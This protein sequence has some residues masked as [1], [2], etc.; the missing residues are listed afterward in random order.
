M[1]SFMKASADREYIAS[2]RWKCNKSP[3][4]SHFWIIHGYKM[5]CKYCENV[6]PVNTDCLGWSAP[7]VKSAT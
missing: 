5:T 2:G 1:Q 7:E 6:K 4:G 3:N